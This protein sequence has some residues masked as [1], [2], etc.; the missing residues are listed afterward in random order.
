M[1]TQ[2]YKYDGTPLFE[3]IVDGTSTQDWSLMSDNK[4]SVS[5]ELEECVVL[6]AGCYIDFD[7]ARFYLLNEYKPTMICSSVW[8][9]DL[10]LGD[11]ASWLSI[12]LALKT[13]D[14]ENTPLFKYTAPAAEHAAII[15]ANLNR[16][17]GTDQW[18]V[19]S[20]ISTENIAIDYSGKYCS[21]VLQEIVDA[22]NT[23]WW[24]DGMTLNIGRAEFG[25]SVTLGYMNGVLG[26]I[27]C[28]TAGDMRSYAYLFPIGSTRNID[29][30]K[31]GHDR[32]QLPSGLKSVPINPEQGVAELVEEAAF[33]HIY[34]RYEGTVS[35][36]R[37]TTAKNEDDTSFLIYYIKDIAIPFNPNEFEIPGLVKHITFQSGE[38]MG[39]EFEVN[40]SAD[41][42]EFELITRWTGDIQ[43]PG[44]VLVP[45][46]GDKYVVWNISMPDVYYTIASHEL[47]D[48]ARAYAAD[49]IKDVSVYKVKLDYIDVQER[50]LKLRPGQRV[51][52]QS[53][54]YFASG[55]Y[56]SRI[57][58]IT[59]NITYPDELSVDI[60]AVRVVGTL[61]RLQA[62]IQKTENVVAQFSGQLPAIIKSNDDTSANDSSVYTSAKSEK[63]FLNKRKGGRVAAPVTFDEVTEF[64]EGLVAHK[65]IKIGNGYLKYNDELG[66]WEMVGD[67][68]VTG[69]VTMFGSLSGFTPS[70]VT[71]AVEVDGTTI[72][73]TRNSQGQ[74][75]LT[76]IGGGGSG[77]SGGGLT[78]AE[79]NALIE[80]AL[81]PYA[82]K[83]AIPTDNNQLSN[84][85]G[86]ITASALTGYASEQW[87]SNQGYAKQSSLDGVDNRLKSVETFFATS[88]TDNLVNKWAEIVAFLN[89]TE[90]DTLDNILKTKAN[91]SALD[92]AVA[93]LTTEIGKKWTQNDAKIANWDSAYGWGNHANAGYAAKTYVDGELAKYVKLSTAQDISAQ[94]NFVNGLKIGGLGI[95]K[96]QDDVIYV[97]ANLVVRGA[98]TMFGSGATIAP[99]IWASIPFDDT[100]EWNGSEWSVVGG[101]SGSVN[102]A[103]VNNLIYEYLTKNSYA[104]ISDISSA[105]TGYATQTWVEGKKYL[106][107][108]TSS[109]VTT[110]LGYTP[111]NSAN[112]TK[113]NIKSTL[114]IS[115]WALAATK[116]SYTA[117]EVGAL[118]L[119]GGTISGNLSLK[120]TN[121]I[122]LRPSLSTHY[123]GIG[124][125][126]KGDE[127]IAIWAKNAATRLRWHAGINLVEGVTINSMMGI[128]PDFE[129][130]K[131]SGIAEGYI[132]GHAII[133]SGN[134][135]SY[136]AGSATKLAT[137][138][139]IWGQSFDGT[140]NVSGLLTDVDGIRG[141]TTNGGYI[142][143]RNKGLGATDGGS[144]IYN[145]SSSPITF[146][147]AGFEYMRIT[148]GG[149]VAIGGTTADAKL[150]VHGDARI[151]G[152]LNI[153]SN[154]TPA[155]VLTD[156]SRQESSIAFKGTGGNEW[157][158]G[159]GVGDINDFFGIYNAYKGNA[160]VIDNNSDVTIYGNLLTT[161]NIE[162]GIFGLRNSNP[163]NPLL[164]L[165]VGNQNYYVQ[166]TSDGIYL[167][168]TSTLSLKVDANGNTTINGYL[169]ATGAIT[170]F[171]Q[172]SMKNVI[173]YDGLSLAQLSQIKP[174]RFTWKD[175]RDNRIHVGGIADYIQP[176]IPEV[177]YETT[178][179]E[180]TVD[181]GSAAFYIGTSLIKPV[182]E[183]WEVKDKQQQE[184]ESLKKRVEYLENENRQFRAS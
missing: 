175:G 51:R 21:D 25:E 67:L 169:L 153:T 106:T 164:R 65:Y 40:Y 64:L 4:L 84:S 132:G 37:Y 78:A 144:M 71:E 127:C 49:A 73:K 30:T 123:S 50:G 75:Q 82:L 150:H 36:V 70:T 41:S 17:M 28:D 135:G 61:S 103:T 89:A 77:G 147:I 110:A 8:K 27:V 81:V 170:M 12:T 5:F 87:V 176:I 42:N 13:I 124:Y 148:N 29:P 138:R 125:D 131:A 145:Y 66:V 112:F 39:Q 48:A 174:A 167:G 180:L 149:N 44:G 155:I 179:K 105:L 182:V 146:H 86:Y 99:S 35:A 54:E 156:S 59:R 181:Y 129:I 57:T 117:A 166:A 141:S 173:N 20:V 94:H 58:R 24:I 162:G 46:V 32:L 100:M 26:D 38:L 19:G 60:S 101:G 115:D 47:L 183:L 79:V 11:A 68:V 95:T 161:G 45:A 62:S 159:K 72:V 119:N 154:N 43:L 137:P 184:I 53:D 142:G 163:D 55:Y 15:V 108:I 80:A 143:D 97:D 118:S 102:E 18:K 134:I 16:R 130:S 34:P 152:M 139:T 10:T 165:T 33:A 88:D 177:V 136:N 96:S 151:G 56:D 158:V 104:K 113:A 23:E 111:Y 120:E 168:P 122:I 52:L 160:L 109:M 7:D 128:T 31:Y 74:W 2:L 92:D 126:T 1:K 76:A 90:G 178:D 83:T 172:L 107:G 63:E 114:G 6:T 9:Y 171:S 69:A 3:V 93:S 85:A 116:P 140:G 91:Q 157:Y 98:V 14:G 121:S 22:K 133:H